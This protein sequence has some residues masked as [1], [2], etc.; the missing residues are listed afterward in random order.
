M[1]NNIRF[2]NH[3]SVIL[4]NSLKTVGTIVFIFVLNFISD[5]GETGIQFTDVLLLLGF[6]IVAIALVVGFHAIIWAKT[7]ITIEENTLVVERNTL[8]KKRNTIGL[9]TISNVNLEQNLLEMLLGTSKVKLDTNSLSTAD[10]TDVNIVLKKADAENFRRLVLAKAE[11]RDDFIDG[12]EVN[13]GET[14]ADSSITNKKPQGMEAFETEEN[15]LIGDLGDII[16]H[17]LYSIR[18]STLLFLIVI[19]GVQ[20]FAIIDMGIENLGTNIVDI[21]AS[22]VATF[23]FVA[24]MLWTIVKEFVKYIG[25]KIQRKKDKVYLSY[26]LFKK[27]AYSVPVDKI[28]GIRLTQTWIA[29]L[30][31]R[32]MVEIINVG[33]DDDE[34]E[35][36]TFF[37]PYS[38][39]ENIQEQLHML[40]PEFDGAIEIKEEKQPKEIWLLSIPWLILYVM[41]VGVAY[42]I[43]LEIEAEL[44][45]AILVAAA[46]ILLWRTITKFARFL[47]RGIKVDD[48][49]LKIVDGGF[50]KRTLFVKYDKIQY[51]TGKQCVIAK[52][53]KIQKGTISLLASMKNRIHELPYFKENDMEQLKNKLI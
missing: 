35:T 37:L 25:F 12:I 36:N 6:L 23:W 53:F 10:Q 39:L 26:G 43:V 9:K 8:N 34:N 22:L 17:G 29:R 1:E 5:I 48:N 49:F 46:V 7:Y 19:F 41:I 44:K 45:I 27:I 18:I 24:I 20:F 2:R 31:K 16:L 52:H 13:I 15:T 30:F 32:Y 4:E 51:V 14:T 50:G 40:L 33:M 11:G 28:N 42:V 21:M 47:T 38:K 3:A